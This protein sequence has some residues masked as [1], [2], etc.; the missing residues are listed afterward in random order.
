MQETPSGER[1]DSRKPSAWDVG[2]EPGRETPWW[3]MRAGIA[4]EEVFSFAPAAPLFSPGVDWG[5][6]PGF[7]WL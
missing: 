1:E 4:L 3:A 2:A 7:Q 5:L 6:G